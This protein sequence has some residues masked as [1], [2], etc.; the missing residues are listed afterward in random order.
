MVYLVGHVG[1]DR[2]RVSSIGPY[3]DG[4]VI[5]SITLE[6]SR[7]PPSSITLYVVRPNRDIFVNSTNNINFLSIRK[8]FT[9]Q[10][11]K[12]SS[13]INFYTTYIYENK[14]KKLKKLGESS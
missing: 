10:R 13:D 3:T 6:M 11:S 5:S 9:P 2:K 12:G 4:P 8:W 7:R 1:R 14:F